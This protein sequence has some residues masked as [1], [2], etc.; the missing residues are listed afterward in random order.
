MPLIHPKIAEEL[1]AHA[2]RLTADGALPTPEQLERYYNT[3]RREFGP[4]TLESLD[5][6]DLLERMH[7]HGGRDSLVY[8]LEFKGDEEFPDLFGSI[9]GGSALKFGVYKRKETGTW[10]TKGAGP[11]PRD[12]SVAEAVEIARRHR[13]QLLA[14]C[15]AVSEVA[16]G[17]DD[18]RYLRLQTRLQK[19]APDVQDTAWG[20][21]YLCLIFPKLLDDFH[22]VSYQQYHLVRMLQLPPN[23]ED[24]YNAGRYVCAGRYVALAAELEV[25]LKHLT[26]LLNRRNGRPRNYWRIG[27]R[28]DATDRRGYWPLLRDLSVVAIGWRAVGDLTERTKKDRESLVAL[29]QAHAISEKEANSAVTQL[30]RLTMD[31]REGDRVIASDGQTVLGVG[32]VKGP[33]TYVEDLP[34]PHQRSVV[35]HSV[36]EWRTVDADAIGTRIA[37]IREMRNHVEIERR[38]LEAPA[39]EAKTPQPSLGPAAGR[40]QISR[41]SG[42]PG[43]IQS[44]LERKGQV[45]LYGPP[46]TGKT[47]WAIRAARDLAARRCYGLG[48][49]E[50]DSGGR[51]RIMFG[52]AQETAL[53]RTCSFHPEYGYEDFIE[54][55]RPSSNDEGQLAFSLTPGVF[56]KLCD[57]AA[58]AATLDFF[59][60][61]DE[62][63]RGDVPRIFGELLTLLERDKRGHPVELSASGETFRVPTNVFV[64]GTM[65]TADRSIALLDVALR[66]RFGFVEL[67]PDY[68]LLREVSV[69]GLPLGAWLEDLNSRIRALG[70]GDARN[71]QIGHAFLLDRNGPISRPEQL[72]AVLR[73]DIVPLLEEYCYDDFD[74]LVEILGAKLVDAAAQRVRRELFDP[75]HSADL[76]AALMRPEIA[77]AAGAL[78]A[79][80]EGEGAQE[81]DVAGDVSTA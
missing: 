59:L 66:R 32:E 45:I 79:E 21:K 33:Y 78:G 17:T 7:A 14:A 44:V 74:Q 37:R 81:D 67:M 3:F 61:I 5:G 75:E 34:L 12:I 42:I 6:E 36:D 80:A 55:Y 29:L 38:L 40:R 54:G 62:I 76:V 56:R 11:A 30:L 39:A 20:H 60:I 18:E 4:Y 1:R 77:T 28:Q 23:W 69:A 70:G 49:E 58:H 65:N 48:F 26:I 72:A 16:G 50:L 73:D 31:V 35:W 43:L 63:N 64:I 13:D 47:Y 19:V 41:L 25:P 57:D 51:T 53:V 10:A 24:G 15:E 52:D 71:R 8:W 2:E 68:S 9:A 27:T 22:V 46:G